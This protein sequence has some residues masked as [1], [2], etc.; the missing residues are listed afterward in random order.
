VTRIEKVEAVKRQKRTEVWALR[1]LKRLNRK[2]LAAALGRWRAQD[3][4]TVRQQREHGRAVG[5]IRRFVLRMLA[6]RRFDAWRVWRAEVRRQ[7][8]LETQSQSRADNHPS[9]PLFPDP[10][11]HP[12]LELDFEIDV[13][14]EIV[15]GKVIGKGEFGKV[16]VASYFTVT[17][18]HT[19][20]RQEVAVKKQ[21]QVIASI[22]VHPTAPVIVTTTT[23][24]STTWP[25]ATIHPS[26][27]RPTTPPAD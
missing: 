9:S 23:S 22:S 26:A 8:E 12:E 21:V 13:E 16:Y 18:D 1:T 15:L 10:D 17:E 11:D 27:H 7:I 6:A 19:L 2:T 25:P 5:V 24:T 20:C 3:E 4:A 14:Q